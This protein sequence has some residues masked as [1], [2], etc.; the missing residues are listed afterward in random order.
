M[1]VLVLCH[2]NLNRSAFVGALITQMRPKW[3]VTSAGLKTTVGRRASRKARAAAAERGMNLEAH[4]SQCVTA[5]MVEESNVTLYMDGGNEKRLRALVSP[6]VFASRCQLL[7]DYGSVRRVPD[8]NYESDPN[9]LA[10]MFAIAEL[11][12]TKFLEKYP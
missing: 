7:A 12:T 3:Q 1:R 10:E 8:P 4:R 11:C 5:Q 6:E 9:R 2:G